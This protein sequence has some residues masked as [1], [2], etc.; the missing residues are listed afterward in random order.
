MTDYTVSETYTLPSKGL[1]YNTP[2]NPR[3]TLRSMTTQEEMKRQSPTDTPY[4][5]MCD[6]IS[7]CIVGDNKISVYDLC[8]ADYQYLL[9]KIRVVT[10]G[11]SYSCAVTC[12]NCGS[13]QDLTINLD[14]LEV[15]EYDSSNKEMDINKLLNIEL[16]RTK[17]TVKLKFETPRMLDNISLRLKEFREKNK[18]TTIDRS[19]SYT[20]YELI[21]TIDGR[22]FTLPEKESFIAKLPMGDANIII[23][24]CEKFN[25][26]FGVDQFVK[27]TCK[28][29]GNHMVTPFRYTREFFRPT[30]YGRW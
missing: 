23:Q 7:D 25:N 9:H 1:I 8:L 3:I 10:Y 5:T 20:L 28:E 13:F 12:A 29:C 21:D 30:I 4:K 2:I 24:A 15:T 18:N 26:L 16:P 22:T 19:L 17:C 14:E 11:P 6:I 27:V